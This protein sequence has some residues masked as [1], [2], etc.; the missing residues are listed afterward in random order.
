M[1]IGPLRGKVTEFG[2]DVGLTSEFH[3]V[4]DAKMLCVLIPPW[5]T[6]ADYYRL[7]RKRIHSAGYSC[8]EYKISSSLLSPDYKY[9]HRAFREVIDKV[10]VDIEKMVREYAFKKVQVIGVSI[11]CI[12]AAMITNHNPL[13]TKVVLVAPGSN[14]AE[15]MWYG[16]KTRNLRSL[17]EQQGIDL[18]FLKNE[19]RDLAPENNFDGFKGKEIE[20]YLS[21]CDVN[22]PYRFGRKL[23]DGMI[24]QGLKPKVYENKFLGHYLTVLSYLW[25]GEIR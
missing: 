20:I 9:T 16:L 7:M 25:K 21:Q 8:L 14:L 19:W 3:L 13:V 23:A 5:K 6:T 12:E 24:S 1:I 22:I 17:F 15:S 11:G 18:P 10:R 4:L 2:G